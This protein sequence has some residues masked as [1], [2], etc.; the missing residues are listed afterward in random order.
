MRLEL[1]GRH[2]EITPP[3]R[4]LVERK[5]AKLDRL[6]RDGALSAQ[7]VL[8]Q[9]KY[10]CRMEITLHARGEK[11]FHSVADSDVWA[12]S[13]TEAVEKIEQQ[14]QKVKGKW[15]ARKRASRG[16]SGAV[17]TPEPGPTLPGVRPRMPPILRTSRLTPAVMTIAEAARLL[18]APGGGI[19]V[20]RQTDA[21]P[22]SVLWRAA[23]GDLVLVETEGP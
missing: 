1:T 19:V 16:N 11:F 12:R 20:F 4:R 15:R 14:A 10:R 5:I 22:V 9:E 3:L 6:L 21:A 17:E 2:V 7:V 13:A 18:G 8:T 23:N